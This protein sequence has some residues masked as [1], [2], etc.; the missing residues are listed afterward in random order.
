M[1]IETVEGRRTL[2][3]IVSQTYGAIRVPL[4]QQF[5]FTPD[6]QERRIFEFDNLEA[7]A[8]VSTYNGCTVQFDYFNSDSKLVEAALNDQDPGSSV[9]VRDPSNLSE[10]Y[11]MLNM[12]KQVDGKIFKSVLVKAV[13]INGYDTSEPVV[14]EARTTV[15]GVATNVLEFEGAGLLYTRILAATPDMA[16]YEQ[17]IPPNSRADDNFP[18]MSTFDVT[19]AED[20]VSINGSFAVLVRKNGAVVTTGYTVTATTF[21]VAVEP[22]DTDVWEVWTAYL[23]A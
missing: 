9:V 1:A 15:A 5:Q 14:E 19:L 13:K 20:A 10:V 21:T 2:L 3:E 6:Y 16:V 7:A 12:R 8:T 22:E 4:A 23:D 11:I 18:A 17:S